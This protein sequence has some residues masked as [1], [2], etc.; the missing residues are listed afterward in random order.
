[1]QVFGDHVAKTYDATLI[2]EPAPPVATSE[3]L[4]ELG[5]PLL[6]DIAHHPDIVPGRNILALI[7]DGS[8]MIQ[9]SRRRRWA[10]GRFLEIWEDFG[11]LREM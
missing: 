2:S 4:N 8:G 7:I 6:N 11:R 10:G 9:K 1:M 3:E 5:L